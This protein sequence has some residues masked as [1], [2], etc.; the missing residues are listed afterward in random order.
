MRE[1]ALHILDLARNSLEAGAGRV[2]IS[3]VE[4]PTDDRLVIEVRDD[5]SGMDAAVRDRVVEADYTTRTTRRWGLGLP[6]FEAACARCEGSLHVDSRPGEGTTVSGV[7]RLS[8]LDRTPL[9]DMGAVLQALALESGQMAVRYEHRVGDRSF[10]LDTGE[11]QG[12]LG[13]A[14]LTSPAALVELH[15]LVNRRLAELGSHG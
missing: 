11:L 6:L 9:G 12:E 5:G 4:D 15:A 3:V 2:E 10:V 13:E 1:L 8:H 7:L 14:G